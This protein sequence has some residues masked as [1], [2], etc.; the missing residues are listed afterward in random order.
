MQERLQRTMIE[1]HKLLQPYLDIKGVD[2][3]EFT[4]SESDRPVD[5]IMDADNREKIRNSAQAVLVELAAL[6]V[7]NERDN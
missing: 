1:S 3:L 7:P 5:L 4:P 6:G 2:P